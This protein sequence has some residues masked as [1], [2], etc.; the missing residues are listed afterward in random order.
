MDENTLKLSTVLHHIPW[1]KA[2][3]GNEIAQHRPGI[4]N[5]FL[6]FLCSHNGNTADALSE[7]EKVRP[8]VITIY[9]LYILNIVYQCA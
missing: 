2:I 4:V 5:D 8:F 1:H 6:A 3:E 9:G 7:Q